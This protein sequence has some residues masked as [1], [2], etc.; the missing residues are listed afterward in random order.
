VETIPPY[1]ALQHVFGCIAQGCIA[2]G[3]IAQG[4]IAQGCI[5]QGCIAQELYRSLTHYTLHIVI[6]ACTDNDRGGVKGSSY[7]A[8]WIAAGLDRMER[9][10]VWVV[11]MCIFTIQMGKAMHNYA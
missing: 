7:A 3:C 1:V 5:A 11:G 10:G 4:C 9:A 2:Q 8:R 6:R